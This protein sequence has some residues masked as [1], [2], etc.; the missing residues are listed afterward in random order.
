MSPRRP[1][2][3]SKA[4]PLPTL[5][6]LLDK[7]MPEPNTGCWIWLGARFEKRGGYG[8]LQ[9]SAHG[10]TL[11]AHR[12]A[13][14]LATGL[15]AENVLHKCDNPPCIWPGH[16]YAGSDGDNLR[17]AYA[18]GRKTPV[19]LRGEDGGNVKLTVEQV[20]EI[21]S[22]HSSSRLELANR[23]GVSIATIQSIRARRNWGWL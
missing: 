6:E 17:D 16:L 23:F 22:L 5:D 7:C 3:P 18:R 2:P 21:R 20:L 9:R 1:V 14:Q 4:R 12:L 8:A 10:G 19:K 11:K 15:E 13:F